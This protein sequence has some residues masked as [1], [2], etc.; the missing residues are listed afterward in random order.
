MNG[1]CQKYGRLLVTRHRTR[2]T[3]CFEVIALPQPQY[4]ATST[5]FLDL[6]HYTHNDL[7]KR[8]ALARP[9]EAEGRNELERFVMCDSQ[10]SPLFEPC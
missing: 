6:R 9:V 1:D 10:K 8:R 7:A 2:G 5:V 4:V 3:H